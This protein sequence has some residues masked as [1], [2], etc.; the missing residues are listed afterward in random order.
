[1]LC[2]TKD[3]PETS[4]KASA[5]CFLPVGHVGITQSD[6]FSRVVETYSHW[7]TRPLQAN[8]YL[9]PPVLRTYSNR[10]VEPFPLRKARECLMWSPASKLTY[11]TA[12]TR[13]S[14]DPHAAMP[15]QRKSDIAFGR[16]RRHVSAV[17]DMRML[18]H[19]KEMPCL[20]RA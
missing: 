18:G 10:L 11:A 17:L 9:V 8:P 19:K 14:S 20:R 12:E 5:T 7:L 3:S 15:C 13:I 4:P 1:M 16:I 2:I 6:L